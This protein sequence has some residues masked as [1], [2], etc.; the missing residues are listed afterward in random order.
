MMYMGKR[1]TGY[2][3]ILFNKSTNIEIDRGGG[4]EGRQQLKPPMLFTT[5]KTR[6]FPGNLP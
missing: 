2:T 3:T 6:W 5:H 4:G 1:K